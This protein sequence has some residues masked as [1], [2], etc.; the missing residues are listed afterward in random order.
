MRIA[1][2]LTEFPVIS[3]LFIVRQITGLL[4]RGHEVAIFAE[5]VEAPVTHARIE[6]FGLL[7]RLVAHP[8]SPDAVAPRVLGA[9]RLAAGEPPRGIWSMLRTLNPIRRSKQAFNLRLMYAGRGWARAGEFD[10]VHAHFAPN[11]VTA[12]DLRAAGFFRAPVI[13]TFHGYGINALPAQRGGFGYRR[14]FAEGDAFTANS[15]FLAERAIALGCPRDRISVLPMGIEIGRPVPERQSSDGRVR[16][17]TV[18]RLSEEKGLGDAIAAVARALDA[19]IALE[20]RIIGAGPL[21][22]A[23]RDQIQRLGVAD[24]V[25]LTGAGTEDEVRR[26]YEESDLFLL[27]SVRAAN[28][29]EEAQGL[30]LQEAQG[31]GLPVIST[32][33]GGIPEGVADGVSGYLVAPRD[34][35]ALVDRLVE[36]SRDRGLRD[37]MGKAGRALVEE[38]FDIERL[39]DRLV[40]LYEAVIAGPR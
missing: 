14:L 16:I 7:D 8:V 9:L 37:R 33:A 21:E 40:E 10:I 19:G 17:L 4:A 25:R 35:D 29:S 11:G 23:L 15:N 26:A 34:V 28:G 24:R 20:Y 27:P 2:V 22:A 3:E 18:G 31:H 6:E 36:C 5:A 12:V 32:T 13:T 38:R 1:F 39:N 30:A